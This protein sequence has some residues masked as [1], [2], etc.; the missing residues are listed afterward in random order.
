MYEKIKDS[1]YKIKTERPSCTSYLILDDQRNILI[2]PGLYQK[3]DLLKETL[4]DIGIKPE[5]INIVLNTHEHADHIGANKY[6]QNSAT[7]IAHRHAANKII[8]A[9][10]EVL[11]CRS[12]GDIPLGYNVHLWLENNNV[13]ELDDWFIKTL[14]TPGHTSGSVCFYEPRKKILFSGDTVFAKGTISKITDSGSYG[15][16]I[17]SLSIIN[18]LKIDLILPG[19]GSITTDVDNDLQKAIGNAKDA[20]SNYLNQ[21]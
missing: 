5:D 17:N 15:E 14:Y 18:T 20:I 21:K 2:D 12:H 16:Y 19:H 4:G 1:L 3:Y 11:H 9:D 8:R 6:F 13:L 10:D 7:I